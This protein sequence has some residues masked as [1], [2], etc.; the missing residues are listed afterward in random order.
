MLEKKSEIKLPVDTM[1]EVYSVQNEIYSGKMRYAFDK[2]GIVYCWIDG[3]SYETTNDFIHVD[4]AKTVEEK[5]PDGTSK[6]TYWAGGECPV[7]PWIKVEVI[8]RDGRKDR[9]KFGYSDG[10]IHANEGFDIIAY[11][12]LGG[13]KIL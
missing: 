7:S 2:D 9:G 5:N 12:I 4:S 3:G 10:W 1:L 6:F 11:R 8:Y 13:Q